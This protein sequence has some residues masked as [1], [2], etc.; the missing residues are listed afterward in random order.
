MS[1][2]N[3]DPKKGRTRFPTDLQRST[4]DGPARRALGGSFGKRAETGTGTGT[5]IGDGAGSVGGFDGGGGS[6]G[7]ALVALTSPRPIIRLLDQGQEPE[8]AS[9]D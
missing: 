1:A 8:H 5:G 6:D 9:S 2:S 7:L 3:Q 4:A